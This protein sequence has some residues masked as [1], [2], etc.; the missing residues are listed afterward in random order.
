MAG[1]SACCASSFFFWIALS[2]SLYLKSWA[3]S[4]LWSHPKCIFTANSELKG[5]K[6]TGWAPVLPFEVVAVIYFFEFFDQIR[7]NVN[8]RLN[9]I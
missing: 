3:L 5:S 1:R 8:K 7:V 4:G 6:I 2:A 9:K